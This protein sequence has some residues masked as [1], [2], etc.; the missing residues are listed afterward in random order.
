MQVIINKEVFPFWDSTFP[1]GMLPCC[2]QV[3][4]SKSKIILLF[5]LIN[6]TIGL[7][8]NRFRCI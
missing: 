8:N 2:Y 1:F 5:T 4:S 6:A 7:Y 3:S